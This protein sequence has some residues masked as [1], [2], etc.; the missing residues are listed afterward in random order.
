[1]FTTKVGENHVEPL[2]RLTS[3]TKGKAWVHKTS[4]TPSLFIAL[5][6]SSQVSM[7]IR[8][9]SVHCVN[10]FSIAFWDC[11]G[12]LVLYQEK[13]RSLKNNLI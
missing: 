9:F 12:G 8:D 11:S 5:S 1:M 10:G 6:V 4:L 2:V 3:F 7:C 13:N